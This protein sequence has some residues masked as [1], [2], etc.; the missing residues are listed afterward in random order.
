MKKVE[1]FEA[2]FGDNFLDEDESNNGIEKLKIKEL[3]AFENHPFK[4]YTGERLNEMV[5]SIRQFGVI[6]PIVVRKKKLRYEILSGHN[7]VKACR[8][9]EVKDIP[10]IIK[11]GLTEEEALLIVTETNLNQRSFT[12]LLHSERATVIAVRHEAM[13]KQGIRSDLL[14]TIEKLSKSPNDALELTSGLIGQKLNS[15]D[16]VSKEYGIS[17]RNISRYLRISKLS[18]E[19]KELVDG[20]QI[21]FYAGVDLSYIGEEGLD[22]IHAI[23]TEDHYKIDMKKATALRFADKREPLTFKVANKIIKAEKRDRNKKDKVPKYWD[24]VFNKYF[25]KGQKEEEVKCNFSNYLRK[26]VIS[27]HFI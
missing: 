11:E 13:K 22:I 19:F 9:L 8:I 24:G 12:D 21:A 25:K 15:R 18:N 2:I 17:A 16:N 20:G 1:T 4:L 23:I 3:V 6:V 7:R 10:V 14:V 5:E 26:V 27:V